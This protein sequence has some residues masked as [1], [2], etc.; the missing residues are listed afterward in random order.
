MVGAHG[1]YVEF[2]HY[3]DFFSK[4]IIPEDQLWRAEDKRYKDRV[5]Y[6]HYELSTVPGM[7]VYFQRKPVVYAD[8][9]PD[10]FYIDLYELVNE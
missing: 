4:L 6:V 8:Y 9:R 2:T 5:K 3:Q 7:K 1:P 10:G